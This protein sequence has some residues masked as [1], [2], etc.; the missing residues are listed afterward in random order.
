MPRPKLPETVDL[1][2]P[3][4]QVLGDRPWGH[5]GKRP[6]EDTS[7]GQLLV[8]LALVALGLILA[9]SC[10]RLHLEGIRSWWRRRVAAARY[11][12][13]KK[14]DGAD[15]LDASH[16]DDDVAPTFVQTL[17]ASF[18]RDTQVP[19]TIDLGS[20]AK[21]VTIDACVASLERVSELPFLLQHA[22]RFSGLA[23]LAALSLVDLW[24]QR[25][26]TIHLVPAKGGPERE[27]G[28]GV[29]PQDVRRAKSFRVTVLPPSTR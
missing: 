25:R 17:L 27:V 23:E 24:L 12:R 13:A 22:C 20:G 2:D 29:E 6:S 11:K 8:D 16:D 5:P 19:C 1:S 21:A 14:E 3:A 4:V 15:D 26:A 28:K 9:V 7:T 18:T 10:L